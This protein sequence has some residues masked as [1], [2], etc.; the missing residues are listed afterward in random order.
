MGSLSEDSFDEEVVKPRG[1]NLGLILQQLDDEDKAT[2]ERWCDDA[3]ITH[4]SIARR[5]K[6]HGYPVA[7]DSIG[8]HRK[9]ECLCSR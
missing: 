4:A 2:V 1:C 3:L 9:Q 6:K 7:P 5:L 8:R